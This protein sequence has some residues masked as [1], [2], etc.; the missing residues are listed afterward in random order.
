MTLDPEVDPVLGLA[1]RHVARS[2]LREAFC[3]E[4]GDEGLKRNERQSQSKASLYAEAIR[5]GGRET[6]LVSDG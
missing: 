4:V 1:P 2:F 3:D 5:I 6:N